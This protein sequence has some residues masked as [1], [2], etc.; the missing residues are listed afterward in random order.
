V[1]IN[2]FRQAANLAT[3]EIVD[4]ANFVAPG[5]EGITQVGADE[6]SSAGYKYSHA[7]PQAL[8]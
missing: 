4:D 5:L 2:A 6:A 8:G 3:R 7:S 1:E